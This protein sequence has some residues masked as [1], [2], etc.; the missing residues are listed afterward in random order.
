MWQ[1]L[2][3]WL[4]IAAVIAGAFGFL[5]G[6]YRRGRSDSMLEAEQVAGTAIA[7]QAAQIGVQDQTINSLR[8]ELS[9]VREEM[10]TQAAK[11][12]QDI[13][14]LQAQMDVLQQDLIATRQ[15]NVELNQMPPKDTL[16]ALAADAG[17][18]IT[19]LIGER[20]HM[21]EQGMARLLSEKGE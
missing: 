1:G 5:L 19:E 10:M 14:T 16:E 15:R 20:L 13:A 3:E 6:S 4:P 17:M 9:A 21:L 11:C 18:R 8:Y 12:T 2:R 7:A